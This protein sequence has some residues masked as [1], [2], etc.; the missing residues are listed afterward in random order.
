MPETAPTPPT[1]ADIRAA[2]AR[3]APH[4]KRTPVMTSS[5]LDRATG[6]RVYL[7]CENLQR[8]GAFKFRGA[9]NAVLSLTDAEA[10]LGVATQSSG[11][12][13]QAIALACSIR[14]IASHI[15]MPHTA[16]RVKSAAVEGYGGRITFCEPTLAAR[17]AT[18]AR[19]AH[20]TGAAVIH[21]YNDARVIAGQGTAAA[22]L[23]EEVPDLDV[24]MTPVSGGG[25]LSGTAIAATSIRPGIRVFAAEP[26]GADDAARSL[27]AGA[28][29]PSDH[30]K[31]IC[32]GLMAGLCPLT[33]GVIRE[34]VERILTVS[35]EETIVAMRFLW[36]RCK[37]VVEPSGAI[38]IAALLARPADLAG[39]R[40]GV[41]I[42][43]GNVD[44]DRLP[45][46]ATMT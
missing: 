12:H 16:P 29:Q 19:I 4:A 20:E 38:T 22:E 36:E 23:L 43:G 39:R 31:T 42:S 44:L 17:D 9:C 35:D 33:F 6:C 1:L 34:R 14:G 32:D 41:I 10:A 11:N 37:L 30:P 26:T 13:A 27:V 3:I 15:V 24:V 45:W 2:A 5:S 40:I 18:L 21:P 8:V 28:L 25:L 7:K 46:A